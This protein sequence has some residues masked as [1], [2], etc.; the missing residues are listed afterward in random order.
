MNLK[1]LQSRKVPPHPL[2][3]FEIQKYY[4]DEPRVNGFYSRD[5]LPDKMKDGEY[6]INLDGYSDTGTHWIALHGLNNHVTYALNNHV[7]YFGRFGV[8]QIPNETKRFIER[9]S[10]TI[11]IFTKQAYDSGMCGYFCI[12]FI[13]FILKGKI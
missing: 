2:T 8:E 11:H 10:I 1:D 5:N 12:G 3:N 13:D 9:F 7:T 6:I 4:Q